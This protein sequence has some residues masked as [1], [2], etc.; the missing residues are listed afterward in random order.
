MGHW[1][2]T[3]IGLAPF[4]EEDL[5]ESSIG[6]DELGHARAL[7]GLLGP[8]RMPSA[9][10][11]GSSALDALAYSRSA[12]EYRCAWFLERPTRSWEDT[13]VR[14]LLYDEAETVRWQALTSSEWEGL[15]ELATRALLEEAFHTLHA[16]SLFTRLMN[17]GE[18]SRQRLAA[19]LEQSLA[20]AT[21]LFEVPTTDAVAVAEGLVVA[22]TAELGAQ[23]RTE[24]QRL[25]D[26]VSLAITWPAMSSAPQGRKGHRSREFAAMLSEMTRVLAL[27]PVARW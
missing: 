13:F 6:Q 22:S 15:A 19:S 14:H 27:D 7:F 9:T 2:A 18:A 5:A 20:S 25:F 26:S 24:M 4:L 21:M 8:E 10:D 12:H 3:R 11:F 1:Y 16:R 17:G 23:W